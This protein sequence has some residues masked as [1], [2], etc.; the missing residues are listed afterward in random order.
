V[1][2]KDDKGGNII[3]L[4]VRDAA[5]QWEIP[6]EREIGGK[7]A[8]L[9]RLL[10][11][12]QKVPPGI[13]LS[14]GLFDE[15]LGRNG[16]V[17]PFGSSSEGQAEDGLL[18]AADS[19][20]EKIL[21]AEFPEPLAQAIRDSLA[22]GP[23]GPYA[24]R[25][26]G[27]LEDTDNLS[28]AGL[29][30]TFLNV[31]A[32]EPLLESVKKC[33]ASCFGRRVVHYAVEHD[34]DLS[35]LRVAVIIQAMVP[36]EKSGVAFTVNPVTGNDRQ[37]VIEAC[38]G[39]GEGLV[40][41]ILTPDQYVYDWMA[42][43]L[44]GKKISRKDVAIV[45]DASPPYVRR[46]NVPEELR[47]RSVLSDEEVRRLSGTALLIQ[48]AYGFPVDI[49][50]AWTREGFFLL[51]ARP[52][53][54]IH[55]SGIKGA[56]TTADFRDGGVSSGVCTPLM[57]SLY[58]FIWE[59][60]MPAYMKK[61][62]LLKRDPGI[63][64][65]DMF[66][67]R[68][69]WNVGVAKQG[70]ERLPGFIERDFDLDLGIEVP[71]EGK[72]HVTPLNPQTLLTG[73]RVLGALEKS[74][75]EQK[76]MVFPFRDKMLKLI[77]RQ[78]ALRTD[79][80][81]KDEFTT[82]FRQFIESE[83]RLS[84]TTYFTLIFHNS[85]LQSLFKDALQPYTGKINVPSLFS[86]LKNL[87]HLKPLYRIW[88]LSRKIL[89]HPESLS[90]WRDSTVDAIREDL[91]E[92]G[93]DHFLPEFQSVITEFFF[94]S[95]KE[96]DLMVPCVEEDPE[97]F[98]ESVKNHLTLEDTH[99]PQALEEHQYHNY[100][101][102]KSAFLRLLPRRKRK[103]MAAMIADVRFFLWWRE[104]LRDISTQYYF[105]IRR[106]V[107]RLGRFFTEDRVIDHEA[108]IFFLPLSVI[109]DILDGRTGREAVRRLIGKNRAYYG[110]FR[111]YRNPNE[112]GSAFS[113]GRGETGGKRRNRK[114]A[115]LLRGI[116][117]SPGKTE[118]KVKIIRDIFEAGRLARGDILITK[119]TDPGWTPY[120]SLLSGVATETGGLLSHAAVISREYGI[121]AV[122][123]VPDLL[124]RL[125]DGMT[126]ELDG[127]TGELRI[128]SKEKKA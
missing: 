89:G 20:R 97:L 82:F 64:W 32:G 70:L 13:V 95:K 84:E 87:S 122:L 2:E 68:P 101:E 44:S 116:P 94:H 67:G 102:E 127:G 72:G 36:S 33:W 100:D 7:A 121:P 4:E 53:T 118:G 40:Q 83:Y 15:F 59:K 124:D 123:A 75:R 34:S 19:F 80:M 98:I 81:G 52:I 22:S 108:D 125:A 17:H 16:M 111:N 112:I 103:K 10:A 28:F 74:I 128:L 46:E 31:A 45:P 85:N 11:L 26:S 90:Y 9:L 91:G 43:E 49:E 99:D 42:E 54:R 71:Y 126:V 65:G 120:F 96:L 50:W 79:R 61:V 115:N 63:I 92:G 41:G 23:A 117:C 27:A 18:E 107:L 60:A 76:D 66:F 37:V 47:D 38:Y 86:G 1:G 25:S 14:A 110:S 56:W 113:S 78:R 5:D 73:I 109:F 88:G 69:Y 93:K 29:Y 114:E 35:L 12:G 57:W 51:Q 58:D 119:F 105:F 77:A 106:Y 104:E 6:E 24:V 8:S 3:R 21:A 62:K 30:E 48:Q 55:T 39:L